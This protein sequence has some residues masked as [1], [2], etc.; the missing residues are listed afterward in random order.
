MFSVEQ[1]IAIR[2][3][4]AARRQRSAESRS[5]DGDVP[6]A[7]TL[8]GI[9]GVGEYPGAQFRVFKDCN[10]PS[11]PAA[12]R[13]WSPGLAHVMGEFVKACQKRLGHLERLARERPRILTS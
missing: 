13:P 5:G 1:V 4:G 6:Q 8:Q 11:T 9:G 3:A 12:W 10:A 7:P 2:S